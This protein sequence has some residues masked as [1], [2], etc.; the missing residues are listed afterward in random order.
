MKLV[1]LITILAMFGV[2]LKI[3]RIAAAL[4]SV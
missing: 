1:R 2:A 3:A 4:I